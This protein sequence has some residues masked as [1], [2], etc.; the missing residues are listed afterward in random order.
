[1]LRL[2]RRIA[3]AFALAGAGMALGAALLVVTSITLRALTTRSIQGDVE[4]TQFAVALAISL[5]LPWCQ[6]RHA[7]IIVDFFTQKLAPR[8][9]RLLDGVGAVLIG[10]MC[11]L[12]AWRTGV[13][14]LS[15]RDATETSM[16]LGLPMWWVYASLA[17]GLA[18]TGLIAFVQATLHF[19]D[20]PMSALEGPTA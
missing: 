8:R 9:V 19:G 4:L 3:S 10:V 13:G 12:L 17:P 16:I 14:A 5:S 1:M 6:L 15:V 20:A 2:L 7:N 18:L 11:A